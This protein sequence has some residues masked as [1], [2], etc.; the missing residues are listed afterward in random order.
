MQPAEYEIMFRAEERH[1]WYRALHRLIFR[2][3]AVHLPDWKNKAIL[4]AGCGTGAVLQQLGNAEKHLGIDLASEA[5]CFCRQRGLQ[6]AQQGDIMS[7]PFANESFDAIICSS[8]LYHRWVRDVPQA[9]HELHRVLRPDGLLVLNLPAYE[10]LR[11]PHDEAVFTAQR[12]TAKSVR[13][14]LCD[15]GFRIRKLTY[16]TTLL[17]PLAVLARTLRASSKGRDFDGYS[18]LGWHN[19]FFDWLMRFELHLVRRVPMPFGVALFCVAQ[20]RRQIPSF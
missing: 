11:S 3:L 6:N 5:I 9:L 17:F 15:S 12:F 2:E 14:L 8:V 7:L 1:W 10:F 19:T 4:D 18:S 16:W 20:K 13:S